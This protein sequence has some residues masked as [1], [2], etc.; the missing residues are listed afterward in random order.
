[1]TIAKPRK[2]RNA[3]KARNARNA[4][5]GF[6]FGCFL[7]FVVAFVAPTAQ[8]T[9]MD[10]LAEQYVKLVL[11]MGQHDPDYVDAF[12]GPDEW[13]TQAQAT[14][15]PLADIDREAAAVLNALGGAPLAA[16]ADELTRLRHQYLTK[17]LR[18]LRARV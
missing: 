16:S 17:Q 1:M 5:K 13:R 18:A 8:T 2:P 10:T 4:R 14:K 15:R 12:Y 9:Q 7:V 6:R 11:A 3:R